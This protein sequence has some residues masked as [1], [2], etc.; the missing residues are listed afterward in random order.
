M[1]LTAVKGVLAFL[2]GRWSEVVSQNVAFDLRNAIHAK[3]S[4]LSFA[5]HDRT[6][7][8]QLLS[9]ADPR[10]GPGTLP[11]RARRAATGRIARS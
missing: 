1:G 10:R 9:R 2:Q 3:L 8:G 4:D 5:Y 6:E 7:T 11:H